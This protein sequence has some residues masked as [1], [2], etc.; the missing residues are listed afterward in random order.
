MKAKYILIYALSALVIIFYS[1]CTGITFVETEV[2]SDPAEEVVNLD[3][4][5]DSLSS[6]GKWVKIT[7]DEINPDTS[8]AEEILYTYDTLSTV[9]S[10]YANL[11]EA[12]NGSESINS[13]EIFDLGK[14][15]NTDY[16]WVP[17]QNYLYEGWTPYT[18]GRWEWTS[19][20]WLWVSDYEW[21]WAT[22]HYGRWWYSESYGWVWSPGY[23]WAPAWVYWCN[24]GEY[25]GWYPVNPRNHHHKRRPVNR[26][27]NGW[28]FV[29]NNNFT[30]KVTKSIITRS[31]KNVELLKNAKNYSTVKVTNKRVTDPG[32]DLKKIEV[33]QGNP[34]TPVTTTRTSVIQ[35]PIR[36]DIQKETATNQKV[37]VTKSENNT[38]T[39]Y[40]PPKVEPPPKENNTVKSPPP[41]KVDPPRQDPPKQKDPPKENP[42][43]KD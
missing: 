15:L 10:L 34:I 38:K 21:G 13:D 16:I 40:T 17:N 22:Y 4:F 36:G 19:S 3:T 32:P 5:K 28:V 30:Q 39:E 9:D 6:Y 25:T 11:E 41:Q 26:N 1:G 20:G 35:I 24:S 43:K 8:S 2:T 18:N 12:M 31:D 23:T 7:A 27:G 29:S 33:A 37:S 14:D 42:N